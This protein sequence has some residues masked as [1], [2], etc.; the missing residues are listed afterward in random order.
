MS[1]EEEKRLLALAR[2]CVRSA[3][4]GLPP[5]PLPGMAPAQG[6]FITI[7]RGD[8]VLGCRGT[9]TPRFSRLDEELAAAACSAA[10]H[11][12]RYRPRQPIDL[13]PLQVTV[14]LI[15]RLEPLEKVA[16][17]RPAEGLVLTAGSKKGIVL[18]W[19]GRDPQTR[20]TWAYRKADVKPGSYARLQ[21]MIA[22]SFRG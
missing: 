18:P 20:L 13:P 11:D 4:L 19:E 5:P 3:V 6:V 15:S 21:R 22:V 17:L 2:A 12:P 7:E 8:K 16:G 1:P 10:A 14:T 9:L